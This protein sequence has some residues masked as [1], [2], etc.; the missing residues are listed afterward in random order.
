MTLEGGEGSGKTTQAKLLRD[1]L[2]R[3]GYDVV[4][5]HEPGGTEAGR[6]IR[7]ILLDP[8][9]KGMAAMTELMLYLASRAQHLEEVITPALEQ[10]RI[11]ICDRFSDSTYAYQIGARGLKKSWVEELNNLVTN[12][13]RP[14][15]TILLD[16]SPEVGLKRVRKQNIGRF[17][18]E[19]VKFHRRVRRAYLGLAGKEPGRIVLLNGSRDIMDIQREIRRIADARLRGHRGLTL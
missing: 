7:E 2:T 8:R 12:G 4:L 15:L 18:M 6:R 13:L 19:G 5:T 11:V 14:A 9:M 10:G 17:E 3:R 1:H 16:C